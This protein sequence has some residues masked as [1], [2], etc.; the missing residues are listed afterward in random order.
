VLQ[1]IRGTQVFQC[2]P[3]PVF[4][5][6]H[7]DTAI[8]RSPE[9][10]LQLIAAATESDIS[11]DDKEELAFELF[12]GSFFEPTADGRLLLLMMAV[13]ART[14]QEPRADASLALIEQFIAATKAAGLAHEQTEPLVN[15]LGNLKRESISAAGQ[16]LAETLGG[17]RYL[18]ESP[19]RFYKRCY[20]LRSKLVHGNPPYPSFDDVNAHGGALEVFVRDLLTLPLG[21]DLG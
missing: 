20:A 16:R 5:S 10:F 2:E 12:S 4:A 18:E 1:D 8:E 7:V 17:R 6:L 19:P 14:V 3:R 21:V 11:L 9:L 15:G 13:E